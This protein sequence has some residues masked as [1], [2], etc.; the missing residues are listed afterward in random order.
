LTTFSTAPTVSSKA[1]R[2]LKLVI[3]QLMAS[4]GSGG[5]SPSWNGLPSSRR[6]TPLRVPAVSSSISPRSVAPSKPE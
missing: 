4:A 1:T 6:S 3:V 2:A 5:T